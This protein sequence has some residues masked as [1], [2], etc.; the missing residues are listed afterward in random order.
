[1]GSRGF[2]CFTY[3]VARLVFFS[4]YRLRYSGFEHLPPGP[5]IVVCNHIRA[6]DPPVLATLLPRPVWFMTK[7]E[8][9]KYPGLSSLYRAL[10]AYPVRRGRA[11]RRAL[12]HTLRIL[13]AGG[14]VL[15]FPEG[16]RSA[17]GE[18]QAP[19]RGVAVLA[20]AAGVPVVPVGVVGPYGF[21][22]PVTFSMGEP[23]YIKQ[24]ETADEASERVMREIAAQVNAIRA[25][26]G[27]A[28]LDVKV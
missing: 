11:D 12:K 14:I 4:Y 13:R 19:R 2:Y 16:H 10:H 26:R 3:W 28:P 27:M 6:M 22:K 9:F 8:M 24:D 21:R 17:T 25:G 15:I 20:R 23:F 7:V 18:L 5:S 1:M